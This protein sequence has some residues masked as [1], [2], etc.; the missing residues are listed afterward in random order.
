MAANETTSLMATVNAVAGP[1]SQKPAGTVQGMAQ[2][3]AQ[4]AAQALVQGAQ[5]MLQGRM[6]GRS[7]RQVTGKKLPLLIKG[8]Q[9]SD[10]GAFEGAVECHA[11]DLA[12]ELADDFRRPSRARGS[13]KESKPA[14]PGGDAAD[15]VAWQQKCADALHR[16]NARAVKLHL[17][18]V[19]D[20]MVAF[21]PVTQQD[22]TTPFDRF[23]APQEKVDVWFRAHGFFNVEGCGNFDIVL[24]PFWLFRAHPQWAPVH[25]FKTERVLI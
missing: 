9:P 20:R 13:V 1:A 19:K 24:G 14:P 7:R 2:G 5:G 10:P 8:G 23:L 17:Y 22:G 21:E 15:E 25:S 6:A 3:A 4:G 11:V 16:I 12:V 18:A